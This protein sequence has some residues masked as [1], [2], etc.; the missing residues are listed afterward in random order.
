[1]LSSTVYNL[2][3]NTTLRST[4]GR[5]DLHD[6]LSGS[7]TSILASP[8]SQLHFPGAGA[9]GSIAAVEQ[10]VENVVKNAFFQHADPA[11][12]AA[13]SQGLGQA[14]GDDPLQSMLSGAG[15]QQPSLRIELPYR[16]ESHA[17]ASASSPRM[18]VEEQIATFNKKNGGKHAVLAHE[19]FPQMSVRIKR[20]SEGKGSAGALKRKD[21]D[22]DDDDKSDPE[23]FCDP[24]V[25]SWSGCKF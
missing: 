13:A 6:A 23:A 19:E 9:G 10:A 16:P 22:D 12:A 18:S 14:P 17:S 2:L 24:S 15:L 4:F 21:D 5:A 20:V 11:P 7:A 8:S 1:L 25:T 3:G